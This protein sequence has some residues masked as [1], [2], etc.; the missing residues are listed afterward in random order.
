MT[1]TAGG[2]E[3]VGTPTILHSSHAGG[4][5]PLGVRCDSI[6]SG[7]SE[8]RVLEIEAVDGRSRSHASSRVG[9]AASQD[10]VCI[11]HASRGAPWQT[12]LTWSGAK[13]SGETVCE[14]PS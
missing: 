5:K 6:A 7:A 11:L 13:S 1:G 10:D 8:T 2:R 4:V 14:A 3:K 12:T 9:H